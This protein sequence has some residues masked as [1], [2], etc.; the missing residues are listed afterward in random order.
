MLLALCLKSYTIIACCS[1]RSGQ[2]RLR[3]IDNVLVAKVIN[4]LIDLLVFVEQIFIRL[5]VLI[6]FLA[7]LILP[8]LRLLIYFVFF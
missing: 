6:T 5:Y 2:I 8:L 4:V 1:T 3:Q 7:Q